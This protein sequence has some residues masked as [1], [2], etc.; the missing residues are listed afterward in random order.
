M[1]YPQGLKENG[2]IGFVAPSFGC[3]SDPYKTRFNASL[4][5]WH[6]KGYKTKLGPNCYAE[7]GYGISSTPQACGQELT[8]G[9]CD[10]ES[11]VLISCGGGELM[12]ETISHV[13]FDRIAKQSLVRPKW[14]QG[15][16]DNTNF[17]FTLTTMCDVASI[18]APCAAS[19]GA[20][21]W[22]KCLIDAETVLTSTDK[23]F[24]FEGYGMWEA[25]IEEEKDLEEKLPDVEPDYLAG[26][27]PN[28][29]TDLHLF[30]VD[31]NPMTELTEESEHVE[32]RGRLI[33]GCLDC[34]VNICG[35]KY[36]HVSQ[37][38]EKYKEDGFIWF[39]EACDL[40][41][42]SVRRA[43][44][45]LEE[46]GWFKFVKGF[47]FGRPYHFGEEIMGLSQYKAVIDII[48][49]YR[50]PVI[51]DADL[52]HLGPAVPFIC[53]SVAYIEAT[54]DDWSIDMDLI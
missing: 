21:E 5:K 17:T 22:H 28:T 31:G 2:T 47:V 3:A 39:L 4:D 15:Y 18:Y 16:S 44:W 25:E 52:G 50:V 51:M 32:M 46:A 24:H 48:S 29:P 12:C 33:G 7:D 37:F 23:H 11:D 43:M 53:G 13:D 6:D 41:P 8:E 30:I 27:Q 45:E 38:S 54:G 26:Y 40:N 19:F 49:H 36:D 42:L 9:Y 14:F 20:R 35:T 1:I 10:S 34:L